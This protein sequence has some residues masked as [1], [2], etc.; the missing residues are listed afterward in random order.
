MS[1]PEQDLISANLDQKI[2]NTIQK[3]DK[4]E[5]D[6]KRLESTLKRTIS[7]NKTNQK[8]ATKNL[9]TRINSLK[10]G[11]TRMNRNLKTFVKKKTHIEEGADLDSLVHLI[12]NGNEVAKAALIIQEK[13]REVLEENKRLEE[14]QEFLNA[15]QGEKLAEPTGF[16]SV[17]ID[18]MY[19]EREAEAALGS[20]LFDDLINKS[21][22]GVINKLYSLSMKKIITTNVSEEDSVELMSQRNTIVAGKGRIG[23][24]KNE[25]NLESMGSLKAT[26]ATQPVRN[27]E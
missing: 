13:Q 25:E 18:E 2:K 16:E 22:I 21:S 4:R 5:E 12:K 14:Q 20:I 24:K 17:I 10:K 15:A 3:I 11:I 7:G 1:Q 8:A 23:A 19:N 6:L 9:L 26:K 27:S